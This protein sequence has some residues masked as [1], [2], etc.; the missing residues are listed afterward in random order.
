MKS[1]TLKIIFCFLFLNSS[2]AQNLILSNEEC[3][4]SFNTLNG[5]TV[6]L[7]K[8]KENGYIIY[9]FGT[10][11]KIEFE[12]P[13]KT[14]ESW[15]KFKY[16]YYLRG[17]GEENEG[18]DLDYL[19][20]TNGS[21]KYII[22]NTYYSSHTKYEIGIKVINIKNGKVHNIKGNTKTQKGD[23]ADFRYNKLVEI[24]GELYD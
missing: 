8:D 14:K 20:F 7:A 16:S 24:D 6:M 2:F 18:M 1:V 21:Y 13:E 11:D 5:K 3:I 12:F 15:S 4:F 10:K 9:K 17:G 22:Y 23:L 19:A